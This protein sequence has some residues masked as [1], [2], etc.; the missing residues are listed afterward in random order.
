M[1]L[2]QGAD[3]EMAFIDDH[4]FSGVL[5]RAVETANVVMVKR[6]DHPRRHEGP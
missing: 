2:N 5:H 6:F 4:E 3:T 1:V